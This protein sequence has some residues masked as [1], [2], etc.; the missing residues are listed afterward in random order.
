MF[1][2]IRPAAEELRVREYTYYRAAYCGLCRVMAKEISPLLSFSLRYDFVFLVLVRLLLT[3]EEPEVEKKRCP[4]PPF[5]R[6]PVLADCAA[7][8]YAARCAA[9]LGYLSI[10]DNVDDERGI[11]RF[12]YRM[13]RP[14]FR[15][16][17][18]KAER[19]E[20]ALPVEE[21]R[22]QLARQRA[23]E[24]AGENSPDAAAEPFGVLLSAV[25]SSGLDG[26]DQRIAQSAGHRI[27]RYIYLCDA[28]DDAPEDKKSGSYNPLLRRAAEESKDPDLWLSENRERLFTSLRLEANAARCALALAE[29]AEQKPAWAC[30]EN[31]TTLGLEPARALSRGK[32][33]ERKMRKT[34][35]DGSV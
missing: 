22:T 26:E 23:L 17:S 32:R 6:R 11:K 5:R 8:R 4:F 16:F 33:E 12:L 29:N 2:Y 13:I 34:I 28:L 35:H 3:E 14:V 18:R 27:G 24:N 31:I 25:F 7:L 10:C 19:S 15:R 30:I 20:P 9:V 21:L 1:G